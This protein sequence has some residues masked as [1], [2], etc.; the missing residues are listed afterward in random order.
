MKSLFIIAALFLSAVSGISALGGFGY[1][2][3]AARK[4]D[5]SSFG[6][7]FVPTREIQETG[8]NLALKALGWGTLYAFTGCGILFYSIWKLSGA[9][10]VQ[11][12]YYLLQKGFSYM[13]SA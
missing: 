5:P 11:F 2:L 12:K 8:A 10:N 4:Q 3:A 1:T 13:F 7:G 6:K 9:K